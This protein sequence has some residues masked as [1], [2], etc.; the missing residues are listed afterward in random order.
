MIYCDPPY[1]GT[2]D[3]GNKFDTE[4]FLDWAD[5]C[6]EPVFISEYSVDDKRFRLVKHIKK[7][8]RLYQKGSS[9]KE[10]GEKLYA[11]KAAA[12]LYR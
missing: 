10:A 5:S 3:Y 11:N 9:L 2:V 6:K 7:K 4:K 8:S 1:K 12:K